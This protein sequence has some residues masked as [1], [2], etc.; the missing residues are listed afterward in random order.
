[1]SGPAV[2]SPSRVVP[3]LGGVT[4][5][6]D[7]TTP[8]SALVDI[9]GM[10]LV[11]VATTTAIRIEFTGQWIKDATASYIWTYL[12]SGTSGTGTTAYNSV[13]DSAAANNVVSQLI[14]YTHTGLTPGTSYSYHM[15]VQIGAGGANGNATLQAAATR[16]PRLEAFAV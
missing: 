7:F 16:G 4:R 15:A 14:T 12:L 9:T 13:A 5:T 6:T 10:S 2:S 1:M 8:S 3:Y 11:V